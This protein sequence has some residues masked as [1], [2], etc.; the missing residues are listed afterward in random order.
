MLRKSN[1]DKLITVAGSG[2]MRQRAEIRGTV[3]GFRLTGNCRLYV[4]QRYMMGTTLSGVTAS[5][6]SGGYSCAVCVRSAAT[7]TRAV[8]H[9]VVKMPLPCQPHPTNISLHHHRHHASQE[10]RKKPS[11]PHPNRAAPQSRST[12]IADKLNRSSR[13]GVA[14]PF[15]ACNGWPSLLLVDQIGPSVK[16]SCR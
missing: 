6:K 10:Q 16:L 5:A 11:Q 12:P 1:F 8:A 3:S 14:P 2:I 4:D 9:T 15:D 7:K 13:E